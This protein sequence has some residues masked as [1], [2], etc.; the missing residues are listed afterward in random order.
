MDKGSTASVVKAARERGLPV[1]VI[2]PN[3]AARE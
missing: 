2:W 1:D 3:G